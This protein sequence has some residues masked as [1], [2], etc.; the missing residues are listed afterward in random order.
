MQLNKLRQTVG[1]WV[2]ETVQ[3]MIVSLGVVTF[4]VLA[5][6]G[7]RFKSTVLFLDN[8]S[9]RYL[10]AGA[11]QSATFET[12]GLAILTSILAL[13]LVVRFIDRHFKKGAR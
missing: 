4:L 7:F 1:F 2:G 10:A 5:I 13:I 9:S 12:L 6:N 3:A 8:F 11:E